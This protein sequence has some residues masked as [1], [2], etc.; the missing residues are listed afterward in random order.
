MAPR[1]AIALD[2]EES[3]HGLL[4]ERGDLDH[5]E[6]RRF[7]L[8]DRGIAD[9]TAPARRV[10]VRLLGH[11]RR[12][13]PSARIPGTEGPVVECDQQPPPD[14]RGLD[15]RREGLRRAADLVEPRLPK[16]L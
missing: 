13:T 2:R 16:R 4:G 11:V 8:P 15:L 10:P 9:T 12:P 3:C 5:L 14:I 6:E 7:V 1:S